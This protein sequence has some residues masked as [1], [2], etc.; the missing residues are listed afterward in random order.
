MEE[1]PGALRQGVSACQVG[2]EPIFN[3]FILEV[4]SD[5]GVYV[6]RNAA[7]LRLAQQDNP[8]AFGNVAGRSY[9]GSLP[10]CRTRIL[11]PR[12]AAN[13]AAPAQGAE[14]SPLGEPAPALYAG[15]LFR[16]PSCIW[17]SFVPPHAQSPRRRSFPR[18]GKCRPAH[19]QSLFRLVQGPPEAFG[20]QQTPPTRA[21]KARAGQM[22]NDH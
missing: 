11:D 14:Q 5:P 20:G 8:T 7:M 22:S 10:P 4:S 16:R 15:G 21:V 18:Q 12:R 19:Q 2:E 1:K 9:R 13:K 17:R 6:Q 3:A